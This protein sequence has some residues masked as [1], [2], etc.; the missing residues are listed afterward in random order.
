MLKDGLC[1]SLEAQ[2][3]PFTKENQELFHRRNGILAQLCKSWS[4]ICPKAP[5]MVVLSIRFHP[6]LKAKTDCTTSPSMSQG[7]DF[8]REKEN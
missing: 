5:W 7:I 8:T 3:S 4:D 2:G 1:Y 6:G